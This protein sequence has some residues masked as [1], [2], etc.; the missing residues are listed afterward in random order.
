M[1]V[2]L[3][4]AALILIPVI[5]LLIIGIG[6][7]IRFN[8]LSRS[9]RDLQDTLNT[10]QEKIQDV[11]EWT[12]S[13][14]A[15]TY[16]QIEQEKISRKELESAINELVPLLRMEFKDSIDKIESQIKNLEMKN[17]VEQHDPKFKFDK[18]SS[19]LE[20]GKEAL[21]SKGFDKFMEDIFKTKH[22]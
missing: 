17:S 7:W 18:W 9:I 20:M 6:A 1:T 14:F 21:K 15:E 13:L 8:H 2:T 12:G 19:F 22:N 16:E 4:M 3:S 5:V 11:R 10:T